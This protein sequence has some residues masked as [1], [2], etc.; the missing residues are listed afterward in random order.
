MTIINVKD[1]I[2]HIKG[3]RQTYKFL[4]IETLLEDFRNDLMT[5]LKE[6]ENE[7]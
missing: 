5:L 4:N 2:K 1:T 6:V 3:A 7:G